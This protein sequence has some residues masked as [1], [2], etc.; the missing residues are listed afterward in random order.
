[1]VAQAGCAMLIDDYARAEPRLL[2]RRTML[3]FVARA[4]IRGYYATSARI[5]E[6]SIAIVAIAEGARTPA[7]IVAVCVVESLLYS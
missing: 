5:I 4:G 1:M 2:R 3:R 7:P 6:T